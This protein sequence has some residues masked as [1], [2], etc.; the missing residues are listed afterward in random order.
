MEP[1][2]PP[3]GRNTQGEIKEINF[4]SREYTIPD[5]LS[6]SDQFRVRFSLFH[7]TAS[8]VAEGWN[9]DDFV[10]SGDLVDGTAAHLS[11]P[12]YD[13]SGISDPVFEARIWV[14]T[15]EDVDGAMLYYSLDDGESWTAITN[16]SGFDTYWNWYTGQPVQALG[17]DGWSGQ[18]GG[19]IR[20]RTPAATGSA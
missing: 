13:L 10:L 15:E 18:S 12:S 8:G 14:D 11:S 9:I 19:W 20:V 2:G 7:S 4:E 6:Y 16:T 1:A 3:F 5:A 17:S